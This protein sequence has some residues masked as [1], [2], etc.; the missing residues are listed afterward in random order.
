MFSLYFCSWIKCAYISERR[1]F[2]Y[3]LWMINVAFVWFHLKETHN[4]LDRCVQIKKNKDIM[5]IRYYTCLIFDVASSVSVTSAC[6]TPFQKWEHCINE[7]ISSVILCLEIMSI[8]LEMLQNFNWHYITSKYD[9]K[10]T[11]RSLQ[12]ND[13]IFCRNCVILMS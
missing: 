8:F 2:W 10:T 4:I 12:S 3:N 7:N 6:K 1:Y 9:I 5:F 11:N 13:K